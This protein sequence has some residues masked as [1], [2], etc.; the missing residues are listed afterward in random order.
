MSQIS[1]LAHFKDK[2][3]FNIGVVGKQFYFIH[4]NTAF[5]LYSVELSYSNFVLSNVFLILLLWLLFPKGMWKWDSAFK[6]MLRCNRLLILKWMKRVF[7]TINPEYFITDT[8]KVATVCWVLSFPFLVHVTT[9][10]SWMY[11]VHIWKSP[12][13]RTSWHVFHQSV[14]QMC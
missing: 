8:W 14:C 13:R 12:S 9:Y 2:I 7:L 4:F 6:K 11:S 5:S 3:M 10:F 1:A